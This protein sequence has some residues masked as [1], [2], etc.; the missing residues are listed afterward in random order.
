MYITNNHGSHFL[1]SLIESKM[2][3]SHFFSF[4]QQF[5]STSLLFHV[6]RYFYRSIVLD[7][8]PIFSFFV[9]FENGLRTEGGLLAK[10]FR[11]FAIRESD[12][13]FFTTRWKGHVNV[14]DIGT[15][16]F[17]FILQKKIIFKSNTIRF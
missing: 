15:R 11:L 12:V 2:L 3:G 7:F 10:L 9:T 1:F 16:S 14:F 13:N 17:D 8:L 4:L 5:I 6:F